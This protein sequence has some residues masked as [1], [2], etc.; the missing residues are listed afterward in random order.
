MYVYNV[1]R[2]LCFIYRVNHLNVCVGHPSWIGSIALLAGFVERVLYLCVLCIH[3]T[4]EDCIFHVYS[5]THRAIDCSM[6]YT[7]YL[8]Y[9]R[10]YTT[11]PICTCIYLISYMYVY[12]LHFV[13][14]YVYDT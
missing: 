4:A 14:M 9:V 13:Y 10:V 11:S 5:I 1:W 7:L 12:R 3:Q 8:L 2:V 6:H